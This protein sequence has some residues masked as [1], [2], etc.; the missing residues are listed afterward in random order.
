MHCLPSSPAFRHTL[1]SAMHCLPPYTAFPPNLPSPL[2]RPPP[3][4]ALPTGPPHLS[5]SP[6]EP[7]SLRCIPPDSAFLPR[8]AFPP[9]FAPPSRPPFA[10]ANSFFHTVPSLPLLSVPIIQA[11][12]K[13][14]ASSLPRTVSS[15]PPHSLRPTTWSLPPFGRT[16]GQACPPPPSPSLHSV[17]QGVRRQNSRLP[18]RRLPIVRAAASLTRSQT[19][20]RGG[21][22][23]DGPPYR[24]QP[25]C[26]ALDWPF[27]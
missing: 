15:F 4:T 3:Y 9:L 2:P 26:S 13:P 11:A 25:P 18:I 8:G 17:G 16:G 22:A 20:R 1:P 19:R 24:T 14:P 10:W 5:S 23:V 7:V 21:I 12:L 6:T 27:V